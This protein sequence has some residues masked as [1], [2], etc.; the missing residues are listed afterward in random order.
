[1]TTS[2]PVRRT[3]FIPMKTPEKVPYLPNPE[4]VALPEPQM[5]PMPFIVITRPERIRVRR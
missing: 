2:S 3:I 1:M 4:R 5:I